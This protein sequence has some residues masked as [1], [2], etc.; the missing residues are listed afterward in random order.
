MKWFKRKEKVEIE[1]E[2]DRLIEV[3]R[4]NE[5]RAV[6]ARAEL[7]TRYLLNPVNRVQKIPKPF[8]L[9]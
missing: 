6:I 8:I 7:G 3:R 2:E 5:A 9:G 1:R 4:R